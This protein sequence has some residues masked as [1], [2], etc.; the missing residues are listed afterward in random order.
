MQDRTARAWMVRAICSRAADLWRFECFRAF[1]RACRLFEC[2][3]ECVLRE[4]CLVFRMFW[5]VLEFA[6]HEVVYSRQWSGR[7]TDKRV[8]NKVGNEK[9][10]DIGWAL[11]TMQNIF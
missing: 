2:F 4:P 10:K 9:Q 8:G 11:N 6:R 1:C 3:L 7:L 5:G